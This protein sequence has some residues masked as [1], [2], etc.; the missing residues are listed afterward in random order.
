MDDDF[1]LRNYTSKVIYGCK[2]EHYED[3]KFVYDEFK[4]LEIRSDT[5][6]DKLERLFLTSLFLI[7]VV[8][9]VFIIHCL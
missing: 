8:G 5:I 2:I 7:T 1:L 9:I 3:D 4:P 6:M